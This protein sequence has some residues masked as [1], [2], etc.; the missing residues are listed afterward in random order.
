MKNHYP[1]NY[2]VVIKKEKHPKTTV[3]F[4]CYYHEYIWS[5]E[6]NRVLSVLNW[7]VPSVI[8]RNC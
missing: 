4:E 5:L 7:L 2:G 6:R 1:S 8:R 3:N